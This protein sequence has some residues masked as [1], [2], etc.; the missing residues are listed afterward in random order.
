MRLVYL[1]DLAQLPSNALPY[2]PFLLVHLELLEDSYQC[3]PLGI[4][5]DSHN[6]CNMFDDSQFDLVT[7]ILE[8]DINHFKEILLSVGLTNK[9]GD[10][11]QTLA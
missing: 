3:L 10:L 1:Q 5:H 9:L 7:L 2:S 4:T 8:E 11:V 6:I